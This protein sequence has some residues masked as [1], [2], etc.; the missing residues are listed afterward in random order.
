LTWDGVGELHRKS[1]S[2]WKPRWICEYFFTTEV[3]ASGRSQTQNRSLE[4]AVGSSGC[5]EGAINRFWVRSRR[6]PKLS[7]DARFQQELTKARN[8]VIGSAFFIHGS[9][10]SVE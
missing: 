1:A 2:G 6:S 8:I 3:A 5:G 10:L 7:V 9:R 4:F